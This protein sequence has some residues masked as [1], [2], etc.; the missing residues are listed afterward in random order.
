MKRFAQFTA[1]FAL[2]G[3]FSLSACQPKSDGGNQPPSPKALMKSDRDLLLA[4]ETEGAE[5]YDRANRNLYSK[6]FG[7]TSG[8]EVTQFLDERIKYYF[9]MEDL[10]G[11]RMLTPS[12]VYRRWTKTDDADKEEESKTSQKAVVGASNLGTGLFYQGAVEGEP[13]RIAKGDESIVID[14]TRVGMMLV[15]PGYVSQMKLESGTTIDVPASYRQ[16][17]LVHEARHSD[18]SIEAGAKDFEVARSATSMRDFMNR[19]KKIECGHAHMICPS[20][21]DYAGISACDRQVFGAYTVGAVFVA[22]RLK[23]QNLGAVER[24]ILESM[25][26]S[27]FGRVLKDVQGMK[28]GKFGDPQMKQVPFKW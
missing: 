11:W 12:P 18:C 28:N 15:G 2:L 14:T 19:F 10:D 25:V 4:K 9:T 8:A 21:H 7:G 13:V 5:A 23:D 26:V 1:A 24:R 20:G 3:A 17:I 6:I 16:S 22:A 27:A